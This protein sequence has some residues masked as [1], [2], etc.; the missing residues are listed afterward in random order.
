MR[1]TF[2]SYHGLQGGV[3]GQENTTKRLLIQQVGVQSIA[4]DEC[5]CAQSLGRVQ[6]F[7]T[8]WTIACQAPLSMGFSGKNTG[9]LELVAISSS[10]GSSW[11]RA[12]TRVS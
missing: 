6:L 2:C 5:L 12:Q 1:P 8:P 11:T 7:G 10:R 4:I 3:I 9:M